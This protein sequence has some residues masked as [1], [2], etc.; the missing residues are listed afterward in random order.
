ML[1]CIVLNIQNDKEPTKF[2][3]FAGKY[4]T[5]AVLNAAQLCDYCAL[6]KTSKNISFRI[7]TAVLAWIEVHIAMYIN[8]YLI[9]KP[10]KCH[11]INI[12]NLC[13]HHTASFKTT[14][15]VSNIKIESIMTRSITHAPYKPIIHLVTSA[16][17]AF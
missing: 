14:H 3:Y 12:S 5:S 17:W 8:I 16:S 10:S 4:E 13:S 7:Q 2:T 1:S 11:P 9:L 6:T 15:K